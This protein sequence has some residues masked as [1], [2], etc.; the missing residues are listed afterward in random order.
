MHN[1]PI[2]IIRERENRLFVARDEDIGQR[3]ATVAIKGHH[4]GSL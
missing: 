1:I 3:E 2:D 4:K